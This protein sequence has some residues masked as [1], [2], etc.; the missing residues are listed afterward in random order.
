ML[1]LTELC[2]HK[3][4]IM[5]TRKQYQLL[6]STDIKMREIS[7]ILSHTNDPLCDIDY[8]VKYSLTYLSNVGTL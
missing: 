1:V 5:Q 8:W 4:A 7:I 6:V 2:L 3:A